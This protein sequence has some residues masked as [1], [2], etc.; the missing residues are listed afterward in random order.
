M[1]PIVKTGYLLAVL[2]P[3]NE[4]NDIIPDRVFMEEDKAKEF[5]ERNKAN[6]YVIIPIPVIVE[7]PFTETEDHFNSP[8]DLE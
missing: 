8:A 4:Y 5:Y 3:L 6:G 7:T 1:N 2:V